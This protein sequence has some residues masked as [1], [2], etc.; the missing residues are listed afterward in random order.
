MEA[1]FGKSLRE[2]LKNL[3]IQITFLIR[4]NLLSNIFTL[5]KL[6][7]RNT[8]FYKFYLHKKTTIL[9]ILVNYP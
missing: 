6:I 5:T 1:L 3:K 7:A 2:L 8:Y 9:V 4:T